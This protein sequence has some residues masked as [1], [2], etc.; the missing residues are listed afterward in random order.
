MNRI[1]DNLAIKFGIKMLIQIVAAIVLVTNL[2]ETS[3]RGR[4]FET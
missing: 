4:V 3:E 2:F 1:Y